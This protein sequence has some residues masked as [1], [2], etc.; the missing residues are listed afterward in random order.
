VLAGGEL[1]A[2]TIVEAVSRLIPGVLG[3]AESLTEETFNK[4]KIQIS[5][6]KSNP[7]S[8]GQKL[9]IGNSDFDISVEYP[10]YTRP[11]DFMGL[12]VPKILLSGD[13]KKIAEWRESKSK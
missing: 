8:K 4:S 13:H 5:N 6:V 9:E 2:L 11:D 10:Q 7:K 1:P 3:N 12:K